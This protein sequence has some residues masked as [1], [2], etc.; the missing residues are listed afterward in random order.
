VSYGVT[1]LYAFYMP[2]AKRNERM[3]QGLG[4]LAQ[5]ISKKAIPPYARFVTFEV[6]ATSVEDMSDVEVPYVR[7]RLGAA[8]H[9]EAAAGGAAAGV[10][11]AGPAAAAAAGVSLDADTVMKM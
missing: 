6:V 2:A 8:E 10:V 3:S 1:I 5:A 11:P 7:Y 9:A 4:H